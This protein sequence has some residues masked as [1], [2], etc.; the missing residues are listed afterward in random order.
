[1]G[2]SG[3]AGRPTSILLVDDESVIREIVAEVLASEGHVVEVDQ[4]LSS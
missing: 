4:K 3:R 2:A 1:V